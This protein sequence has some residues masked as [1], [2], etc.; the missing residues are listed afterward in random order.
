MIHFANV[1]KSFAGTRVVSAL[2]LTIKPGEI[3]GL[4]GPN[5]A[6][7]T[8]TIRMLAGV[9]PPSSGTITIDQKTYLDYE[10]ELK[11]RIGYLPE[12]NP[13]YDDLTVEE[14]LHFWASLKGLALDSVT[15]AIDF[16]VQNTGIKEVYYRLISELSK[17]Y[18]QRVGLAQAI[19]GKPD[20]LLLDEP[21][22]GL[23]PNQRRDIQALL[24]KLKKNRTVIV[25]SHVLGEISQLA[26]RLLIIHKGAIV[27]DDT[28][29][30]LLAGK[31]GSQTIE[32]EVTG[33]N[34]KKTLLAL[35]GVI[36]VESPSPRHYLVT[37]RSKK[38][39]RPEL[40]KLAVSKKWVLTNL[41]EKTR[42]LEDVFSELTEN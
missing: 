38:D 2:N 3:I 30:H 11:H 33:T 32:L 16:A 15:E 39:L 10:L 37:S 22:E 1:S 14:H 25:S 41:Q 26:T 17:G 21:T 42:Q 20:I 18:R 27:G 8:T 36:S 19:L 34:I 13:L 6:G 29:A 28:L 5:G 24:S 40:F 35:S 23:D 7:K 12:N 31:G 4:L 9:L